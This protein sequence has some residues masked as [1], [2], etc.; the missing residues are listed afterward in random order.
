MGNGNVYTYDP[1]GNMTVRREVS[2]TETYVYTQT[3]SIDNRLI[4]V[5]KALITG[6][7]QAQTSYFFD[8]DG[9][10]VR[11]DDPDGTTIYPSAGS[12]QVAGATEA[13]IGAAGTATAEYFDDVNGTTPSSF[14]ATRAEGVEAGL[15]RSFTD[16]PLAGM[17]ATPWAVRWQLWLAYRHVAFRG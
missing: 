10:R 15:T 2:G 8:G 13:V 7:V 9:V 3:W 6:A 1:N 4:G 14:Y 11:K 5:T 17:G 16:T 12:G